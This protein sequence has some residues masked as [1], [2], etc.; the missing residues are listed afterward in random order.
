M[1]PKKV[2]QFFKG[3][4]VQAAERACCLR[5]AGGKPFS[6]VLIRRL[7]LQICPG[8]SASLD[9]SRK[10]RGAAERSPARL[11]EEIPASFFGSP[12]LFLPAS[13]VL[14][15]QGLFC[16][17]STTYCLNSGVYLLFGAPFG[18]I[19]TPFVRQYILLSDKWGEVHLAVL[20]AYEI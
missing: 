11:T 8:G 18:I 15:D 9:D 7:Q 2:R 1:T 14:Q 19:N 20:F 16:I 12:G 5:R 17:V 3:K 6:F 10:L 13:L 4:I